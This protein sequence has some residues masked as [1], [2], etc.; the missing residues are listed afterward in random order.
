M[1]Y[2]MHPGIAQAIRANTSPSVRDATDTEL[3][4]FWRQ[5]TIMP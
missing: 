5:P 4:E 1:A 3:A 2:R